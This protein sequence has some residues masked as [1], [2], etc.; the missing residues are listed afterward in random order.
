M[1]GQTRPD[2]QGIRQAVDVTER[3]IPPARQVKQPHQASLRPTT[4]G[5]RRMQMGGA[6][7]AARQH[8]IV[9]GSDTGRNLFY[10]LFQ[11]GHVPLIQQR[12]G[13]A[14]QIFGSE[15]DLG[16][17]IEEFVLHSAQMGRDR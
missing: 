15:A 11:P 6:R 3:H 9:Q 12:D 2:E 8:E 13:Q 14:L 7:G 10:G 17:Q 1:I 4:D 5:P 16:P